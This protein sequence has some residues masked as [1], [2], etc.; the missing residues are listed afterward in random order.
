MKNIFTRFNIFGLV[1]LALLVG[2]GIAARQVLVPLGH[3]ITC[4]LP[5][6]VGAVLG[7]IFIIWLVKSMK[8]IFARF[9]IFDLVILALL[10]GLGIA[11]R[12]VLVP[13]GRI[14][15]GPLFIPGGAVFGGIFMM[16]LV[17]G[18][19]IVKKPGSATI[20]ALVQAIMTVSLGVIGTHGLLTFATFLPPGIAI[21]T[22]LFIF[23]KKNVEAYFFAGMFANIA[24]AFM[25]NLV[26]F[27]LPLI[28]LA[29]MLSGAAISGGIGGLIAYSIIKQ[30]KVKNIL[31]KNTVELK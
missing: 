7:G 20:V 22:I 13:L 17:L 11:A 29:V 23:K 26:F 27:R 25:V 24:G 18:A 3:I 19:G 31:N 1:I 12:Q 21:D 9:G 10:A 2:L 14:I 4:L 6:L 8:Y 16:W 5:I 15:T 28:P 30:F